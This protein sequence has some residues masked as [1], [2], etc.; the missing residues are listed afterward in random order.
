MVDELRTADE[1]E[2]GWRIGIE[3]NGTW[4]CFTAGD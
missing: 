3:A 1:S 2:L 4:V